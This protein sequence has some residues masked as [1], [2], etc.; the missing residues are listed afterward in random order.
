MKL[1]EQFRI[2]FHNGNVTDGIILQSA[3]HA[4][5]TPQAVNIQLEIRQLKWDA[6]VFDF[7]PIYGFP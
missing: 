2:V 1:L 7:R 5:N 6:L 3:I 4:E